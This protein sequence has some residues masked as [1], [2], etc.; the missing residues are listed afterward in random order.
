MTMVTPNHSNGK[1]ATRTRSTLK[2]S[3]V[4]IRKRKLIQDVFE[5]QSYQKLRSG[6]TDC[7][8]RKDKLKALLAENYCQGVFD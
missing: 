6:E 3:R 5:A 2:K 7:N 1:G 4:S 8:E